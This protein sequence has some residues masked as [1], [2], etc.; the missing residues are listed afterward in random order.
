MI[1]FR[2]FLLCE[3]DGTSLIYQVVCNRLKKGEKILVD[4]TIHDA[5][6]AVSHYQGSLS[7]DENDM[8]LIHGKVTSTMLMFG[9]KKVT[10]DVSADGFRFKKIKD[11]SADDLYKIVK[12]PEGFTVVDR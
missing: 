4:L 8:I 7:I 6:V 10:G 9:G 2:E 5:N 1:T 11:E 12:R 3:N